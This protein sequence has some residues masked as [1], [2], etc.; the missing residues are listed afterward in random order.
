MTSWTYLLAAWPSI[1]LRALTIMKLWL[2]FIVP[3]GVIQ[4]GYIQAMGVS[5]LVI[6]LTSEYTKE[7][8]EDYGDKLL[9]CYMW[10]I[11][12]LVIGYI[13]HLCM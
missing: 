5:G 8:N 4:L 2:W 11:L 9:Y 12:T 3:L 6:F 7:E 10:P 1:F 13:I